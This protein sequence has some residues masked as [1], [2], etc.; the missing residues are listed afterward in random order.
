LARLQQS[1][2]D[3]W[4]LKG[5]FALELRL[6][7]QGRTTRDIDLD[8]HTTLD[9][10]TE[11]LLEAASLD[12]HDH[13]D[14]DVERAGEADF[15]GAIRFRANA[16][17]AGR[18]FEQLLID[19]GVDQAHF[20]PAEELIT[21]DLLDF[22]GIEPAHVPAAPLEQHL[23]EKLHAY[24]R[25][26]GR[27]HASSRP[28][29]LI[30]MVLIS[31]LADFRAGRLRQVVEEVFAT[32]A[33]HEL[34]TQ[35]PPPPSQWARPYRTLATEVGVDPDPWHGHRQVARLLD[36]LLAGISFEHRWDREA[37]TWRP[38]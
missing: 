33:T 34:P 18:L 38:P 4:V 13:F 30:D 36:P 14:F 15:L 8:W 9:D 7:G 26:Y 6:G 22:A 31:E 19:V 10:A 28:K 37:L 11:V 32:R 1:A 20:E 2:P 25:R 3:K 16:S 5:G 21:P 29:D 23:A 27:G 12:L 24:T 35:L 17:I